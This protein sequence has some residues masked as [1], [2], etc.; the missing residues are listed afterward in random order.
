M[1]ALAVALIAV[2]GF[3]A[4][5]WRARIL[6]VVG[7]MAGEVTG[8]IGAM[9]DKSLDD[10]AKER[11]VQQAGLALIKR[12]WAIIWRFGL[13]LLA[14]AIPIYAASLAGYVPTEASM[15]V[16]LR[17][18]F[19]AIVSVA[20]CG[21][22]WAFGRGT[23]TDTSQ[24]DQTLHALAFSSPAVQRA[25]G[26][27]DSRL[28]ARRI[29]PTDMGAPIFVTSLA[30]G[31][32]TAV[33][34]AL[35]S[36]P[37]T[38]THRYRDMPFLTAPLLWDRLSGKRQVT[39]AE[40][41]HGDGMEID[42]DSAEAFDEVHW[43][44]QWPEKYDKGTIPLWGADDAR[45]DAGD[46]LQAEFRK[47]AALRAPGGSN[48]R[49]LSKNNANIA[50]LAILPEMFPGA[51]IIVP[52]RGPAAHAASLMRQHMNFLERHQKDDHG[53]RYMADIGH[54]EFGAL[55]KRL[56]FEGDFDGLSPDMPDYWLTY[57][58]AAFEHVEQHGS[59]AIFVDQDKLRADPEGT[60]VRLTSL[61][62]LEPSSD[63]ASFFRTTPDPQPRDQF[64]PDLMAKADAL[65]ARL[66]K[67]SI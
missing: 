33:L 53:R 10:D 15:G 29:A 13:A 16:M 30:R 67:R 55:H 22:A 38:A 63:F 18:D 47:I 31:G 61:L 11:A 45:A 64:S 19:I 23:A 12:G 44:L 60:M 58:I 6:S 24:G 37:G 57:W 66:A 5:L 36:L 7:G 1:A 35:A 65:Y 27:L 4:A 46:A 28:F 25:L 8:G 51:Q 43:M 17:L 49:Y 39:R 20:A 52:L 50:R 59:H 9:F 41:A 14:A 42:L 3:A 48:T 56:G 62:E 26:R 32:T 21:A 2:A 40:R 34:N 54:F